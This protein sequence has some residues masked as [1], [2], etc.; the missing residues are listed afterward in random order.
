M[1]TF[2]AKF[3]FAPEVNKYNH[4][5]TY[6]LENATY[7]SYLCTYYAFLYLPKGVNTREQNYALYTIVSN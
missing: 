6:S 3:L 2:L 7:W 5:K 4:L 1:K